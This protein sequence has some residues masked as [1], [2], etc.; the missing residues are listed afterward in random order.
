MS[1]SWREGLSAA[2]GAGEAVGAGSGTASPSHQMPAPRGLDLGD[3]RVEEGRLA[4]RL[5]APVAGEDRDGHAPPP[6]ARDA[7]V[8]ASLHHAVDAV[9][10][11]R[12]NPLHAVDGLER[13]PPQVL[14]RHGHEPLLGGAE[15]E[16]VLAA[17]AVRVGVAAGCRSA[18]SAPFSFRS[19]TTL[20]LASKTCMPGEDARLRGEGPAGVHRGEDGQAVPHARDV[21]LLAVPRRRVNAARARV[22]GDVVREDAHRIPV[23]EGVAEAQRPPGLRP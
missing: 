1:V 20:G 9:A 8:G 12:R 21:V 5:L 10:A 3:D 18:R 23:Q 16:G 22:G 17:P 4:H 19:S 2:V 7:P 13:P 11:P 6:L 14:V 15:D